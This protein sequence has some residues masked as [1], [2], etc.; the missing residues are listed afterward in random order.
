[1]P[2]DDTK[3]TD[4][5]L[6]K[7]DDTGASEDTNKDELKLDT[8]DLDPEVAKIVEE[9]VKGFQADYTKKTQTL[10][11]ERKELKEKVEKGEY[12]ENWHQENKQG[13][14]EYN[15]SLE[16]AKDRSDAGDTSTAFDETADDVFGDA[17]V[18]KAMQANAET[19]K[20]LESQMTSGFNML[21]D[22][23]AVQNKEDYAEIKVDPK[24]VVEF[25]FKKKITD[26]DEAVQGCYR[27]EI[28]ETNFQ[29]RLKDEKSKWEEQQKTNVLN[30]SMPMGRTERRVL[31]KNRK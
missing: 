24:K 12:W 7:K 27:K 9:K 21:V 5:N 25:A 8:S 19:K 10:A 2:K 22:L 3:P 15:A 28:E 29:K 11:Q 6:D 18:K 23:F 4:E 30:V 20:E 17:G 16:K 1:M 31:A 14:E 26:M 13:I